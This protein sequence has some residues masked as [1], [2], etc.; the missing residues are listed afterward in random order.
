MMGNVA[1]PLLAY[2]GEIDSAALNVG[3]QIYPRVDT[4][5][6]LSFYLLFYPFLYSF[7]PLPCGFSDFLCA[8]SPLI[9]CC[10]YHS[11]SSNRQ[12]KLYGYLCDT[13]PLRTAY[14]LTSYNW[15]RTRA[16]SIYSVLIDSPV[17]RISSS[18]RLWPCYLLKR[19]QAG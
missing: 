10:M 5:K 18:S 12:R 16:S 15:A 7:P 14:T 6:F 8:T 17:S 13:E 11:Q 3:I 4:P 19:I 9:I 1:D 2:F